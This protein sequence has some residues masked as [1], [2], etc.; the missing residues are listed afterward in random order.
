MLR[1]FN[2]RFPRLKRKV[3]KRRGGGS[4]LFSSQALACRFLLHSWHVQLLAP[5][6]FFF[7]FKWN[8][9]RMAKSNGFFFIRNGCIGRVMERKSTGLMEELL[10]KFARLKCYGWEDKWLI[11]KM[12]NASIKK[13]ACCWWLYL[14]LISTE[15]FYIQ[16]L[17]NCWKI[18]SNWIIFIHRIRLLNWSIFSHF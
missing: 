3:L 4:S 18:I 1:K 5:L 6:S 14:R 11:K 12:E 9:G 17:M 15:I 7:S 13:S 10:R 8:W 2:N 16:S